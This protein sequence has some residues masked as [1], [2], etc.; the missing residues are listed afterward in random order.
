M[1]EVNASSCIGE[2]G[3]LKA[4][5]LIEKLRGGGRE[6]RIPFINFLFGISLVERIKKNSMTGENPGHVGDGGTF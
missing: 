3:G 5:E 4:K 2:G 1:G 6:L